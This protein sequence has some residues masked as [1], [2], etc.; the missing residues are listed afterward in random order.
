MSAM[1]IEQLRSDIRGGI[2]LPCDADYHEARSLWNAMVD[3]HPALIV[4]CADTG[5]VAP[6]IRYARSNG[7][8]IAVRGAGHNIAGSASC[9]GGLVI[10]LG[11]MNSVEVDAGQ[12]RALVEPGATLGDIDAATQPHGLALPVGINSTTG[13]AGLT[14]GGGFGWLTRRYGMTVDNLLGA[15]VTLANGDSVRASAEENPAL[16]W[17]LRGGGGNFGVVTRFE[18][19]LQPVGPEVYA[20]LLVFPM[21]QAR[22]I[23]RHYQRFVASAPEELTVW[24]VLRKAPPLPFL[25]EEVHGSDVLVLALCYCGDPAAGD[26]LCAPLR[27]FGEPHGTH[28]GIMPLAA[29]QQA[30]DPLLTK[31]ARN[32]WKTHNF[33]GLDDALLDTVADCA[34]TLPTEQC[35]IF[36]AHIAGAAN[37]VPVDAMA[38][39]HRDARFVMNLHGRWQAEGDDARCVAWARQVF[40]ATRP[41]ASGGAYINFMTEDEAARVDDAY[42]SNLV[43][44]QEIKRQYDPDNVFHRNQNIRP[45]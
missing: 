16:F 11:G 18:F 37:R 45:D 31:G 2:V 15:E 1:T 29:W 7:L 22:E 33:T 3:R 32:Y 8:E 35:E 36:I 34:A 43:R 28:L 21:R 38:Y 30:F 17:A 41:Y 40:E 19:Q 39:G 9:D 10:D 14:L 4:R 5:D 26:S 23:L 27:Q 24:V 25:P 12:R 6:A 20:G 42:G 13:I 44:L